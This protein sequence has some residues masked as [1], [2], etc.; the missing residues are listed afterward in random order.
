MAIDDNSIGGDFLPRSNN[1]S[2][3]HSELFKRKFSAVFKASGLH[4]KFG[5]FAKRVT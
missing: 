2:R 4:S 3:S 1:E 5:E